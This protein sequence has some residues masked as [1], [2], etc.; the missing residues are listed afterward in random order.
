MNEQPNNK[1]H[2]LAHLLAAAVQELYPTA[3]MTIGPSTDNG[4]YYDFDFIAEKITDADLAKIEQKMKE[5]LPKW[6]GFSYK[7]VSADEAKK[8][9]AANDYKLELI[10]EIVAKGEKITLYTCGDF[11]DLCRG[12]HSENPAENIAPDS[13]KLVKTAGAYWRG[14]EKNKM[15]TRIYGYAFDTAQELADY[16]NYLVEAEKRDHRKIG[17][18]LNLFTF[19]NLVGGGLPL[20][21]PKGSAMR[22]A[23][24]E[25]IKSIQNKFG[26]YQEV[27]IPH[28]TKPDLYKTS[29]HWDKFSEELF[30]IKGRDSEFVMKPMNCPHHTQIFASEARSYRDLPLRFVETTTCYRDEQ[31][32]E[33][34]G[35]SRVRALTQDD[36]H[37]FC[38]PD[39]IEAEIKNI[40]HVIK[41]FYTA[42]GL[43][44]EGN[45]RVSLSTR[46][47]EHKEKFLGDDELWNSAENTLRQIAET[48]KLPYFEG[49]GDAAF[50][51]PKLDFKFKDAIG[52]EWQ[53]ATIQLDFNMPTR[54]NLEYTD[55]DSQKK[56]PVMIHRAI[57][58]SLERFLSVII[59]HFAGNFPLWL[60]PEQ[61]VVVP[62]KDANLSAAEEAYQV[63]K[64]AGLRVRLDDS[65]QSF[66]KKIHSA[67]LQKAPYIIILGDKDVAAGVVTLESR[68][69]GKIGQLQISEVI[70]RLQTELL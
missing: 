55:K 28:I 32:G 8:F 36:G 33:L 16:E 43:W 19:S 11:T 48:E 39:Q 31:T 14:D 45:F 56:H 40:Y 65:S 50:Y 53:L 18:E 23:I 70:H 62:V 41:E 54:F 29:G 47:P 2:S 21:T 60:A 35:L 64:K 30:H 34:L 15:L 27:W 67:Q 58:G 24:I 4:F 51:G 63:L 46:D 59:E 69:E 61:V 49:V 20:F 10:D 5:L 44:K 1:R 3:K 52:R 17:K 26:N 38:R 66:G 42:L 25:K 22:T 68:D 7:E 9:F 13:F 6:K 12:G 37:I 57:A